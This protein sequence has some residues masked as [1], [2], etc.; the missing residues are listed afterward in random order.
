MNFHIRETIDLLSQIRNNP[1]RFC[2]S[3]NFVARR[4]A[5]SKN[6]S[7]SCFPAENT[8]DRILHN[9]A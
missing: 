7:S 9:K 6:L 3:D 4:C 1:I 2:S 5:H 8:V